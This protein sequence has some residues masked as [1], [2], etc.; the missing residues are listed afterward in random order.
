MTLSNCH[1]IKLMRIRRFF[2]KLFSPGLPRKPHSYNFSYYCIIRDHK[3]KTVKQERIVF[4]RGKIVYS[5][6]EE[7]ISPKASG[8]DPIVIKKEEQS[9]YAPS[10][11]AAFYSLLREIKLH[12]I[13]RPGMHVSTYPGSPS[14]YETMELAIRRSP[15]EEPELFDIYNSSELAL[16][17]KDEQRFILVTGYIENLKKKYF[18]ENRF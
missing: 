17:G 4:D 12:T 3:G 15:D 13:K 9:I 5:L 16:D 7:D 2:Q 14:I 8:G 10:E 11:L 18:N 6:L 1:A